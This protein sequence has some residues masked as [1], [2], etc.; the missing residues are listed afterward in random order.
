MDKKK[1]L[2]PRERAYADALNAANQVLFEAGF[3]DRMI[4]EMGLASV[5]SVKDKTRTGPPLVAETYVCGCWDCVSPG[6]NEG[7][8]CC[9]GPAC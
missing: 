1:E 2:S 8:C 3:Q 7:P 6:C 4:V 9:E 5:E